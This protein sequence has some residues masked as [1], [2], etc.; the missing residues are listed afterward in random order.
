[1]AAAMGSCS[2]RSSAMMETDNPEVLKRSIEYV[3]AVSTGVPGA[4]HAGSAR[5]HLAWSPRSASA[6]RSSATRCPEEAPVV[7]RD[8]T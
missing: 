2:L 5:F 4:T 6:T 3:N 1:M 7:I 8:T